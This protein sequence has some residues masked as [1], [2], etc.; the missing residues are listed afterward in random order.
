MISDVIKLVKEFHV[1]ANQIVNET[2]TLLS[3]NLVE[4]RIKWISD[5]LKEL[6]EAETIEEQADA[7]T[8]ALYYLL[9]CYVELGLLNPDDLFMTIHE[10]NMK[11]L[12]GS[13]IEYD[14]DGRV[15]KPKGWHHPIIKIDNK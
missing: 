3:T 11:K 12:I 8:D 6:R 7:I 2:P 13:S 4:R 5:E 1:G 15:L 9:G 10:A 14:P